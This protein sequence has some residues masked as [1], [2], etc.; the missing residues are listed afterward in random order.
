MP[1]P[2]R[3]YWNEIPSS[4]PTQGTAVVLHGRG[5]T[6]EDLMPLAPEIGLDGLRWIFPD[7]PFPFPG[8][9]GRM[10]HGFSPDTEEGIRTSR[11][12]LFDL[13]DHLIGREKVPAEKLALMGFSQGAV[14]SLDV[15][16]RYHKTLA[17]IVALSGYLPL[18]DRLSKEKSAASSQVPILL[19]HGTE[20]DVV[21]VEGSRKAHITLLK[22]GYP[23]QL[24]E[25]PMG[26]TVIPEEIQ[27]IRNELKT[28][29]RLTD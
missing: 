15:G 29:L 11:R 20:D 28:A 19:L 27:L 7:A 10:W 18:A 23:A 12:M 2:S 16:L 26:H 14:M 6:G 21:P 22:E 8:S 5:T 4:K 25:Y 13:L 3:L 9:S 1:D 24:F 17:M